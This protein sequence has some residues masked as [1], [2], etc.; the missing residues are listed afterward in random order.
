VAIQYSFVKFGLQSQFQVSQLYGKDAVS[1]EQASKRTTKILKQIQNE[2]NVFLTA[3]NHVA[4][5]TSL[6]SL[7]L[8]IT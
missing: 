1:K 2:F 8:N 5:V 4:Y 7:I 6:Q 3:F